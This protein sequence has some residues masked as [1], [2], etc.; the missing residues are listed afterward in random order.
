MWIRLPL[1]E[2]TMYIIIVYIKLHCLILILGC[3]RGLSTGH[4]LP[5]E[6]DH[7]IILLTH[8]LRVHF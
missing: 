6:N 4:A 2:A 5:L 7:G 1:R 8:G 3:T